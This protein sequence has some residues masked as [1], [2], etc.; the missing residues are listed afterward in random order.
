MSK[1]IKCPWCG[2]M[3]TPEPRVIQRK[4]AEVVE[5]RCPRCSKVLAAYLEQDR[6]FMPNI[7]TF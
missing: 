6:D 2:E 3:V 4:V 5:R 7:R 1:K